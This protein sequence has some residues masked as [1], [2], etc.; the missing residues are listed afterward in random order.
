M[1]AARRWWRS[2]AT[3]RKSTRLNSSHVENSYAVFCLKKKRAGDDAVDDCVSA[4]VLRELLQLLETQCRVGWIP[5]ILEEAVHLI[6]RDHTKR[7][8]VDFVLHARPQRSGALDARACVG[9]GD[10]EGGDEQT[11]SLGVRPSLGESDGGEE[12]REAQE[13]RGGQRVTLHFFFTDAAT[14]E[15]YT[16]SLH[17]ALPISSKGRARR[18]RSGSKS[19]ATVWENR[20]L[21][22][23]RDTHRM[24]TS[25]TTIRLT[26]PLPPSINE[27][28]VVVRSE[29]HTSELQ[30]RRDLVCRLLLEK[31]KK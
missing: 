10:A 17:D 4:E 31:K 12:G 16:L 8:R 22:D 21:R 6:A 3:D 26:L 11:R 24:T 7:P 27:Q 5:R 15:I 25:I 29:E 18:A 2:S 28:Y 19:S 23:A 20:R 30:S 14:T 9:A 13:A 1:A